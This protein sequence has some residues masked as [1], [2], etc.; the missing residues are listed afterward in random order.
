MDLIFAGFLGL[1]AG[2]L[3]NYLSD[4]LPTQR[5]LTSPVCQKCGAKYTL[6]D[7]F[8]LTAC[9]ACGQPRSW[10][11]YV[12]LLAGIC[13]S[14]ALWSNPPTR[15]G[16]WLGLCVLTYLSLVAVIDIEHRLILHTV[17]LAGAALGLLTGTIRYNLV[18]SLLG[19]LAGLAIMLLFYWLGTLF[20]RYRARK[21]GT[22]DGEEALGFGD[23][24]LATVLGLMLGWPFIMFG[25]LIGVLAGG[26]ISLL[27]VLFLV[28]TRRFQSMAVFTA[29]GPYLV[30]GAVVLLYFPKILTVLLER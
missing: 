13:L 14:L 16:Y 27:L 5:R 9:R 10:R 26:L 1:F 12:T 29:Y 8:M 18:T 2:M 25:L 15:M 7:Y 17:S 20:A 23:V 24:T 3:V 22:D 28:A 4:V 6:K 21:L 11:T 30:L 19:G